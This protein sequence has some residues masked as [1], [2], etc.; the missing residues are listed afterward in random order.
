MSY[1]C[2]Y[3]LLYLIIFLTILSGCNISIFFSVFFKKEPFYFIINHMFLI[4]VQY[5]KHSYNF[6]TRNS[7]SNI[8]IEEE[9]SLYYFVYFSITFF[10]YGT[11]ALIVRSIDLQANC[12]WIYRDIFLIVWWKSLV[13]NKNTIY[14][15]YTC[16]IYTVF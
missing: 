1:K 8:R 11:I 14:L 13:R 12:P 5:V 2:L 10:M 16:L 6:I 15:L 7:F 3:C 4:Y 9:L